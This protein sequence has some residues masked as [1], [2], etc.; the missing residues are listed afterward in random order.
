MFG[1]GYEGLTVDDLI[2]R[3]KLRGTDVVVDVRLN[4]LSR[5][6]GYS[7]RALND[8]LEKAGIRYVHEKRLGNPRDNR[9][10]Y[11]EVATSDGDDARARFRRL[12]EEDGAAQAIR[13]LVELSRQH[14]VALLCFESLEENCHREQVLAAVRE[15]VDSRV[16]V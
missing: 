2:A 14:T 9:S 7:K 12:L 15:A 4:A 6:K 13:E 5:K 3:L 8:A 11:A 16:G 1:I 10:A